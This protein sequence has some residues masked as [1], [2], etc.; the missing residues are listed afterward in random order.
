VVDGNAD[1]LGV[2]VFD[3]PAVLGA[4]RLGTIALRD[5]IVPLLGV[6]L[7]RDQIETSSCPIFPDS[8]P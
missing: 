5:T 2:V 1:A 4:P 7:E 3:G 8:Q 6:R